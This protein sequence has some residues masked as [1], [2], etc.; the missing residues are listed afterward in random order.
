MTANT[1][2]WSY[3]FSSLAVLECYQMVRMALSS[4]V[5]HGMPLE[6]MTQ[7]PRLVEGKLVDIF[8]SSV[9]LISYH[10]SNYATMRFEPESVHAANAGLGVARAWM[11]KIKKEFSWISYGDL[12]TLGGVAAIQVGLILCYDHSYSE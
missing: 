1:M 10:E 6:L 7:K 5:S 4:F 9:S 12:W 8:K 3:H 2:V 11:E